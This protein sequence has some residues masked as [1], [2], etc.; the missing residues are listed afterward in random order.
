MTMGVANATSPMSSSVLA[1]EFDI[2]FYIIPLAG[3]E[4]VLGCQ[5]LHTLRPVLCNS[6]YVLL[7][8]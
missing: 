8:V 5:W 4:M 2:D 6:H 3:F 1:Q 7:V